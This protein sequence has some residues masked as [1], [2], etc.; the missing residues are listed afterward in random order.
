MEVKKTRLDT[1][2][3]ASFCSLGMIGSFLVSNMNSYGWIAFAVSSVIGIAWS[4]RGK[5][6]WSMTM[7][8]FF[9]ISNMI[10]I[11]NYLIK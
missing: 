9:L 2:L 3:E 6:W 1:V 11:Y 8:C 5:F 7:Q 4:Y 10:G